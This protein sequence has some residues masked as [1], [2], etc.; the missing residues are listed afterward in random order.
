MITNFYMIRDINGY[1]GFGLPFSNS[2]YSAT[3]TGAATTLTVPTNTKHTQLLAVFTFEPGAS[4]WVSNNNTATIPA[5]ATFA[6][7][8]SDL[9]PSARVVNEGDVL[10]FITS[11]TS[12]LVGVTFYALS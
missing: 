2:N 10:S 7:T 1:N 5:G 8:N 9:N 3:I 12:T 6:A 11:N 4:V